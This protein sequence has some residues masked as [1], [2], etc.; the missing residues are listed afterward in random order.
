MSQEFFKENLDATQAE[1]DERKAEQDLM[2]E[3]ILDYVRRKKYEWD[4]QV[5]SSIISK[6]QTFPKAAEIKQTQAAQSGFQMPL[7]DLQY[8]EEQI[9]MMSV[10]I[11]AEQLTV[12]EPDY[13][14]DYTLRSR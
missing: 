11:A 10:P 4:L 8:M 14:G 1:I 5:A 3:N 9:A 2:L 7:T 13:T 12:A 6:G